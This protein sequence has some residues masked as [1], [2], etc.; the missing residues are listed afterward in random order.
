MLLCLIRAEQFLQSLN[1]SKIPLK[2]RKVY[3]D[4]TPEVSKEFHF[5]GDKV[6]VQEISITHCTIVSSK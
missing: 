1:Y 4:T 5:S 6:G 3:K 2:N